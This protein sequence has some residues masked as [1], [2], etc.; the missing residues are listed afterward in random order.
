[1]ARIERHQ[2]DCDADGFA[3]VKL[4]APGE[5]PQVTVF[6]DSNH[7][8][9]QVFTGDALPVADQRRAI[10]IEPYTCAANAF[11]NGLGL[12]VLQPGESF[13]TLWG[14]TVSV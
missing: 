1:M 4:T 7:Q 11:N 12:R 13:T 3:R 6:M 8:F 10:A 5:S 9:L 14:I 2:P